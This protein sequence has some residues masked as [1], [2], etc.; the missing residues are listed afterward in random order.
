M[1]KPSW[2]VVLALALLGSVV[3]VGVLALLLVGPLQSALRT[4]QTP[5]SQAFD[6]GATAVITPDAGWSVRAEGAGALVLESPDRV[7]TVTVSVA[8]DDEMRSWFDVVGGAADLGAADEFED[9]GELKDL[10]VLPLRSEVLA[11]G[12]T[13]DYVNLP[14]RIVGELSVGDAGERIVRFDAKTAD[15]SIEHYRATVAELLLTIAPR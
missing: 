15:Q 8:A 14:D 4:E 12:A 3:S 6:I 11:N 2:W 10:G 7:L 1:K 9:L 5:G 13:I